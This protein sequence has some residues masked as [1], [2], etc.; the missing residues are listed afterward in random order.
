MTLQQ[1]KEMFPNFSMEEMDYFYLKGYRGVGH[2]EI[3]F[4]Y[5]LWHNNPYL[6]GEYYT[7]WKDPNFRFD[8]T[9]EEKHGMFL[10][11]RQVMRELWASQTNSEKENGA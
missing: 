2:D 9:F 7:L 6:I 3:D 11:R 10:A 1:M 8:A 5:Y 4:Y